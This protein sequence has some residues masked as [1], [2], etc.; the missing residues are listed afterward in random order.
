MKLS[1]VWNEIQIRWR[2][3]RPLGATNYEVKKELT[4]QGWTFDD[5]FSDPESDSAAI[6]MCF[7]GVMAPVTETIKSPGGVD[8]RESREARREFRRLRL[9]ASRRIQQNRNLG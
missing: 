4:A 3:S 5:P 7:A 2:A 1:E 8:I 9:E 6:G